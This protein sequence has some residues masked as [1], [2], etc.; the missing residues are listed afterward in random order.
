MSIQ[1]KL[2]EQVNVLKKAQAQ[3]CLHDLQ[4][5]PWGHSKLWIANTMLIVIVVLLLFI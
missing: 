2:S 5:S 1:N 4:Q 3:P